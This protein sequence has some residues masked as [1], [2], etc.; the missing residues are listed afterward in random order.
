MTTSAG[1][2]A[3]GG[4]IAWVPLASVCVGTMLAASSANTFNQVRRPHA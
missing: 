2:V 4:P 1:F 3:A